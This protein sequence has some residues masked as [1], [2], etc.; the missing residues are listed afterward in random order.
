M[1]ADDGAA[2]ANVQPGMSKSPWG[3]AKASAL[4]TTALQT[5]SGHLFNHLCSDI[6]VAS[7]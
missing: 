4:T 2:A 3:T 5:F 7:S 6:S 1:K